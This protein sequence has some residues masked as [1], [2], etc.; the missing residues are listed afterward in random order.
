MR[1]VSYAPPLLEIVASPDLGPGFAQQ[2]MLTLG[3]ATGARWTVT[4]ARDGGAPTLREQEEAREAA[5][6]EAVLADPLV[7]QLFAAFPQA[8]LDTIE[9]AD[10]DAEGPRRISDA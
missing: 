3:K 5:R 4:L 6:R 8:R 2:L 7:R 1:L 9:A 10:I